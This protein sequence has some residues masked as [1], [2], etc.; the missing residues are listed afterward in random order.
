MGNGE[1]KELMCVTH[2]HEG[3]MVVGGGYRAE[4]SKGEEKMGQL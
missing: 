2:G 1:T 4:G 3:G